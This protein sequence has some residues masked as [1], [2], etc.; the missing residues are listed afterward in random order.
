MLKNIKTIS[1]LFICSFT[2][3]AQTSM[4]VTENPTPV[5]STL[6]TQTT[7]DKP[8]EKKSKS[9]DENIG[10]AVDVAETKKHF[11]GVF[12]GVGLP[13]ITSYG[14]AYYYGESRDYGLILQA[15]SGKL[16]STVSFDNKY[17]EVLFVYGKS[18]YGEWN[19]VGNFGIG[20]QDIT[21]G[22]N[23]TDSQGR[24]FNEQ[25]KVKKTYLKMSLG[26]NKFYRSGFN[27]GFDFG[28]TFALNKTNDYTANA[29]ARAATED[30]DTYGKKKQ[31]YNLY[32]KIL[33]EGISLQFN[34]LKIGWYF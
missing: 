24:Y 3:F 34:L 17:K 22:A 7:Q 25:D 20:Q 32:H 4:T 23:F 27:W 31:Q 1:A 8:V 15:G 26:M 16:N 33:A 19:K 12:G 28:F 5:A 6:S 18:A 13:A 2:A 14:L 30:H 29:N 21:V 9:L 11:F 10:S